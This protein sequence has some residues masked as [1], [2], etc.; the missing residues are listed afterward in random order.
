MPVN[1]AAM[2]SNRRVTAQSA[3][4]PK[5]HVPGGDFT[6]LPRGGPS[7]RKYPRENHHQFELCDVTYGWG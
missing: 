3:Y 7:L 6:R 5:A 2:T 1:R 4:Q